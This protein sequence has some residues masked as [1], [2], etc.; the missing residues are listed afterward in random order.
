MSFFNRAAAP[1]SEEEVLTA[2][3]EIRERRAAEKAEQAGAAALA[4]AELRAA[5][6][7][8]KV[9]AAT[10]A[11]ER[12]GAE[13][14]KCFTAVEDAVLDLARAAG[15]R[16]ALQG[17]LRAAQAELRALG[18]PVPVVDLRFG[19]AARA[20]AGAVSAALLRDAGIGNVLAE[21]KGDP[22][23]DAVRLYPRAFSGPRVG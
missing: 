21:L 2:A 8:Q 1:I 10:S 14:T 15:Q 19:A 23:A 17:E 4:E 3:D 20:A 6:H 13:L 12:I 16:D 11:A 22:L 7:G 9:I 5:A 18:A